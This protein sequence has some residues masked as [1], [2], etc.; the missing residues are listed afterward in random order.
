MLHR[1]FVLTISILCLSTISK[2]QATDSTASDTAK[3]F[4]LTDCLQYAFQHQPALKQSYIDEAIA[5]T[6]NAINLSSWLPQINGAANYQHYFELPTAFIPSGNTKIA[7]HTGLP[8]TS[9]PEITASQTIFSP[10]VLFAARSAKFNTLYAQ[11]TTKSTKINLVSDVSKAFYDLLLTLQQIK[12][13]RQDTARLNKNMQDTYNEYVSGIKDKVDYSQATISLNNTLVQLKSQQEA[14]QSK[15]AYLKQLMGYPTEQSFTVHFDTVQMMQ[16]TYF[17]TTEMLQYDKRIEYKQLLTSKRLQR[18]TTMYYQFDFLPS[19]SAFYDYNHEYE[20]GSFS[21]L[22]SRAYPYSLWGLTLNIPIFQ[23]FRR[24]E[25]IHKAKLQQQRT[26]W[27]EV[28]MKLEIYTEYKE[29]LAGYKSNYYNLRTMEK[30]VQLA[31]EVYNIVN[32]QYRE[33][34]KAYL[35]VIQAES[36][37][38]TTEINYLNALF[39]LLSSKIDLQ[40]AM[41]DISPEL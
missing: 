21:D 31:Q 27:D 15:F 5:H 28:N 32:L 17:D 29:A 7:T 12:V 37:L 24:I 2:A 30:N 41:G 9:T 19:L 40:R 6:N 10:D 13:L 38:H 18:E 16:E 14:V 26:D 39:Q 22:Y 4:S 11:Q 23:G 20:S 1:F 3:V 36:D 25:N 35:D 8:Y 33:G 34:I